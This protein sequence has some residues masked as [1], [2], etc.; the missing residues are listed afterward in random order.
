[1]KCEKCGVDIPE[2]EKMEL[3]GRTVCED[4][5]IDAVSPAKACDPW[6]VHTAKSFVGKGGAGPELNEVQQ[7]ILSIL[8]ETGGCG[9]EALAD[10]LQI[11]ASQLERELAALRHMEKIK[12]KP[13]EGGKLIILW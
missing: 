6:A 10:M 8:K 9:P 1:M 2:N 7:H 13:V 3:H 12:G 11:K 4:C 5:Y